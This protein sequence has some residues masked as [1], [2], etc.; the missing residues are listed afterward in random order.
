MSSK[1][2]H[3]ITELKTSLHTRPSS[4]PF[5]VPQLLIHS[6]SA[7]ALLWLVL[8]CLCSGKEEF[9]RKKCLQV[10]W[11]KWKQEATWGLKNTYT[12]MS[13]KN[14]FFLHKHSVGQC[15]LPVRCC[16]VAAWLCIPVSA[17]FLLPRMSWSGKLLAAKCHLSFYFT[18]L[19]YQI[20]N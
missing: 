6:A 4:M 10:K 1:S 14:M 9:Y 2:A 16:V 20:I 15:E 3:F 13:R 19:R 8:L 7:F 12:N 5:T 18:Y 11:G 17:Q